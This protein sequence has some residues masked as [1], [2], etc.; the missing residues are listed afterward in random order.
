MKGCYVFISNTYTE[1]NSS[2]IKVLGMQK[3]LKEKLLDFMI[4]EK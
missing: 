3:L 4:S 1:E 2:N